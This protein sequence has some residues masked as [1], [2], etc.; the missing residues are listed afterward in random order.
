[1]NVMGL[2]G[3]YGGSNVL[4]L[5]MP[6]KNP[7]VYGGRK[8]PNQMPYTLSKIYDSNCQFINYPQFFLTIL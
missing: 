1:M 3:E 7:I 4:N 8:S 2:F 6:T 5:G